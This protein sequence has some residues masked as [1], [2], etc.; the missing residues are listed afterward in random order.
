MEGAGSGTLGSRSPPLDK[1]SRSRT[2]KMRLRDTKPRKRTKL[3]IHLCTAKLHIHR[4]TDPAGRVGFFDR[5]GGW[6][7]KKNT[8]IPPGHRRILKKGQL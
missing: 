2:N 6:K 1:V 8:A 3:Y 7:R 5:L 4:R